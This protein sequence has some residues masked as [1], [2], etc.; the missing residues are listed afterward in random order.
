MSFAPKKPGRLVLVCAF[1]GASL[2][3]VTV[4]APSAAEQRKS[5]FVSI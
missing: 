4:I 2:D 3:V 1:T 5:R